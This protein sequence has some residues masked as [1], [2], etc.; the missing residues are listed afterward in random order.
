MYFTY[1]F[2]GGLWTFEKSWQEDSTVDHQSDATTSI[3]A[4]AVESG[5]IETDSIE[6]RR[7]QCR[8]SSG[9]AEDTGTERQ[10]KPCLS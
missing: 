4:G 7:G 10:T 2:G 5:N 1:T 8:V 9:G 6:T 3:A